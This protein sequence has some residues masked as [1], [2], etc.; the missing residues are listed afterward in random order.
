MKSDYI[1]SLLSNL[2]GVTTCYGML[3]LNGSH[4]KTD[5]LVMQLDIHEAIEDSILGRQWTEGELTLD[6]T[7]TERMQISTSVRL[8]PSCALAPLF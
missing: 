7:G 5:D 3:F 8:E 2:D 4:V 6:V 1:V